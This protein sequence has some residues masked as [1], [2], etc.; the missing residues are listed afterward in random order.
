MT[1]KYTRVIE[2]PVSIE[3]MFLTVY[4]FGLCKIDACNHEWLEEFRLWMFPTSKHEYP[5][6]RRHLFGRWWVCNPFILT[7]T[8]NPDCFR[9]NGM[10]MVWRNWDAY[11]TD[12]NKRVPKQLTDDEIKEQIR[13]KSRCD[14]HWDND[15]PFLLP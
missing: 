10:F 7:M 12:L 13:F 4:P 8:G 14:A 1:L 5:F 2:Y 11:E 9:Y 15:A 3:P 6:L